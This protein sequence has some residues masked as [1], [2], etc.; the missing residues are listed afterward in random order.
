MIP[1]PSPAPIADPPLPKEES[2]LVGADEA[3]Y[4]RSRLMGSGG[5]AEVY[6]AHDGVLDRDV[7]LKVLKIEYADDEQ[8]VE[9]FE[10]EA[11]NVASLSH[12]NIVAIHYRG[13]TRDGSYFMVMECFP[14]GTLKE[15]IQ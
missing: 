9:R 14:G 1:D 10:R 13:Q 4:R 7:T 6:L 15:R 2:R 5:M 8:V 12:P 11:R 3:H